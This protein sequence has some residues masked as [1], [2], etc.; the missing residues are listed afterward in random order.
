MH[1]ILKGGHALGSKSTAIVQ[2]IRLT[3][4]P[5]VAA[6]KLSQASNIIAL[7]RSPGHLQFMDL[8]SSKTFVQASANPS[9]PPLP[10]ILNHDAE[11]S[12]CKAYSKLLMAS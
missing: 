4:G 3:E 10:V 2:E 8:A 7:Q 1:R 11:Q 6:A 5:T 12:A 9:A